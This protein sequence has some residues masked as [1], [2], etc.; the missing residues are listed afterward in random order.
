VSLPQATANKKMAQSV[1]GLT[2]L[3][4]RPPNAEK[5]P[6]GFPGKCRA[7]AQFYRQVA[8]IKGSEL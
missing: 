7:A 4:Q 5:I 6:Q 8:S 3:R 1:R 2:F